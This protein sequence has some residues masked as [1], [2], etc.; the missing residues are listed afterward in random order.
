M[1][2][3]RQAA[4]RDQNEREIIQEFRSFGA[5]VHQLSGKGVPDLIVGYRGITA[6]VEVKMPKGKLTD[7]QKEFF[8]NWNGGLLFIV[9]T[10]ADATSV[11]R[12][13]SEFAE[14]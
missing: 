10:V 3:N 5:S 4:K 11:L 14:L 6:L 13:I 2:I 1:S 9:R 7:D 8:D 12:K